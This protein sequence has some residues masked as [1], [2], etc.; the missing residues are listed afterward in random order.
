MI[1]RR[2]KV[3]ERLQGE[4]ERERKRVT[5]KTQETMPDSHATPTRNEKTNETTRGNAKAEKRR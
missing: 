1:N 3:E 4:R 5:E 2:R